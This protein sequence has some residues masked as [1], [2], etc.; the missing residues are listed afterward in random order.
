MFYKKDLFRAMQ[1]QYYHLVQEKYKESHNIQLI[2]RDDFVAGQVTL[3]RLARV[4]SR[5]ACAVF[6]FI[7]A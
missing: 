5:S 1:E 3:S 4:S 7:V 6:K 2:F